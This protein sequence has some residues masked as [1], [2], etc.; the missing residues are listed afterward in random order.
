M[1]DIHSLKIILLIVLLVLSFIFVLLPYRILSFAQSH[2]NNIQRLIYE[3]VFSFLNCFAAGVF[4]ATCFLDLLPEVRTIMK[5]ALKL[6]NIYPRHDKKI[7]SNDI[8]EGFPVSEFV[9]VFGIFLILI[10]EQIALVFKEKYFRSSRSQPH[11]NH[12]HFSAMPHTNLSILVHQ[13]N[14]SNGGLEDNIIDDQDREKLPI[15]LHKNSTDNN[16]Y[17]YGSISPNTDHNNLTDKNSSDYSLHPSTSLLHKICNTIDHQTPCSLY[18][19]ESNLTRSRIR[20]NTG[21]LVK[22][23]INEELNDELDP[24]ILYKSPDHPIKSHNAND[25]AETPE[26]MEVINDSHDLLLYDHDEEFT[27][28]AKDTSLFLHPDITRKSDSKVT[29]RLRSNKSLHHHHHHPVH[30]LSADEECGHP[31]FRLYILVLSLSVHSLFEGMAVALQP[32]GAGILSLFGAL[33][34]HKITVAFSLGLNL[35]QSTS[36]KIKFWPHLVV[37]GAIFSSMSPLGIALTFMLEDDLGNNSY[38][39]NILLNLP[40]ENISQSNLNYQ[41]II[42][43]LPNNTHR[44]NNIDLKSGILIQSF[45]DETKHGSNILMEEEIHDISKHNPKPWVVLT[46]AIL[47]GIACG[48]FLYV[49][50][51]ELLPHEMNSSQNRLLKVIFL[52]VGF[53]FMTGFIVYDT[54]YKI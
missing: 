24:P 48:T 7:D 31:P 29:P 44:F 10:I 14:Y 12:A 37:C 2:Q 40:K 52:I 35:V 53:S 41:N 11:S 54:Y 51:F 28:N 6:Y 16:N 5:K 21:S 9:V 33:C 46:S 3:R 32:T 43:Y 36:R 30:H 15:L 38:D 18:D 26:Y 22:F 19:K 17:G 13:E 45:F 4:L 50:F 39:E 20:H 23:S 34:F 25:I 49:T 47:Q 27:T 1:I 42:A 8:N